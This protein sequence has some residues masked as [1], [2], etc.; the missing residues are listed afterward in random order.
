MKHPYKDTAPFTSQ[1]IIQIPSIVLHL[2]SI[3]VFN[4][5]S[6]NFDIQNKH[7]LIVDE[8]ITPNS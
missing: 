8:V 3:S 4:G 5:S 6:S 2:M 1:K 7:N